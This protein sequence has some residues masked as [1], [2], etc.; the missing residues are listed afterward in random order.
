[1][2]PQS[3]AWKRRE[4]ESLRLARKEDWQCKIFGA[5]IWVLLSLFTCKGA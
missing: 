4:A 1:M 3:E 2:P 5:I